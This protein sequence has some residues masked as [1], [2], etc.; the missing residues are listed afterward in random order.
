VKLHWGRVFSIFFWFY[1][2]NQ[3][4]IAPYPSITN[5]IN[6]K[7]VQNWQHIITSLVI[8]L[9]ASSVAQPL[10]GYR[11]VVVVKSTAFIT[12]YSVWAVKACKEVFFQM[13]TT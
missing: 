5:H 1:T 8:M 11:V 7:T 6:H 3:S 13:M 9:A 12:Y 10:A 4:T 2:D